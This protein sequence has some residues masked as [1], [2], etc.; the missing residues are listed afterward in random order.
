MPLSKDEFDAGG[1]SATPVLDFLRNRA[2]HAF[3]F[4]ELAAEFHDMDIT[5]DDLDYALIMLSDS[6]VVERRVKDDKV[7]YMYRS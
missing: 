2:D 3:T 5:L 7:Y 1:E 6:Q 4:G